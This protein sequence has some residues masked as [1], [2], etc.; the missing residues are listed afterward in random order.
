MRTR[1]RVGFRRLTT[2]LDAIPTRFNRDSAKHEPLLDAQGRAG[3][4][5]GVTKQSTAHSAIGWVSRPVIEAC[6][7]PFQRRARVWR[8]SRKVS[9]QS[10]HSA[11]ASTNRR[12][13]FPLSCDA[14]TDQGE[15]HGDTGPG[16]EQ[17]IA[18]YRPVTLDHVRDQDGFQYARRT[19]HRDS[20]SAPEISHAMFIQPDFVVIAGDPRRLDYRA[21]AGQV[22]QSWHPPHYAPGQQLQ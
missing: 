1:E 16:L 14:Y 9:S 13:L 10:E 21:S 11:R 20:Q 2:I 7:L 12:S 5:R 6:P 4:E 17:A 18:T 3:T 22:G 15:D 19:L 8:D